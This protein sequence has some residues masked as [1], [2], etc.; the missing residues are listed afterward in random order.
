MG[1][2]LIV[3]RRVGETLATQWLT[4]VPDEHRVHFCAIW[5][6]AKFWLRAKAFKAEL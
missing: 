3:G 5:K 1:I 6:Q 2:A 4:G